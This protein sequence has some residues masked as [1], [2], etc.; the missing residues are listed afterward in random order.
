MCVPSSVYACICMYVCMYV[1]MNAYMRAYAL[2]RSKCM[3]A[4]YVLCN[5]CMYVGSLGSIGWS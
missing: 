2:T 3:H 1:C 5:V 4:M